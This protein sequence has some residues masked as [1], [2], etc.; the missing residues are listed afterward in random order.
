MS[1]IELFIILIS[2]E[3]FSIFFFYLT[4]MVSFDVFLS[5]TFSIFSISASINCI[6]LT[7]SISSILDPFSCPYVD[8][9]NLLACRSGDFMIDL[10]VMLRLGDLILLVGLTSSGF[11]LNF[12][13]GRAACS[14]VL[15]SLVFILKLGLRLCCLPGG[16]VSSS[17]KS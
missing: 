11:T 5:N 9:L 7:L 12:A 10:L 14:W 4:E 1:R 2:F 16:D 15:V 3:T 8:I 13:F 17:T 6:N